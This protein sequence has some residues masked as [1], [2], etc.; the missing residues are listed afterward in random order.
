MRPA[1][2]GLLGFGFRH[3]GLEPKD[4]DVGIGDL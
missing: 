3:T 2:H 1:S 4:S